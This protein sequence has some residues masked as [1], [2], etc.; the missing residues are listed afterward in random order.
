MWALLVR[1]NQH[2]DSLKIRGAPQSTLTHLSES[3]RPWAVEPYQGYCGP[4]ELKHE[5]FGVVQKKM[6][7]PK[8]T[9]R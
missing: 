6:A 7:S 2:P 9:H 3:S 4:S 8:D 1:G 5:K